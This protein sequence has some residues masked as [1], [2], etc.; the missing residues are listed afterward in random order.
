MTSRRFKG[1][2]QRGSEA[3]VREGGNTGRRKDRRGEEKRGEEKE[4]QRERKSIGGN[5]RKLSLKCPGSASPAVC[6]HLPSQCISLIHHC[7]QLE[8]S[9]YL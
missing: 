8:A 4:A 5:R 7:P 3:E 1:K 9:S 2:R 6:Q